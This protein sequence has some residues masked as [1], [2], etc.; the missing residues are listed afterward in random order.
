[1]RL[2][3]WSAATALAYFWTCCLS[4][5]AFAQ[6]TARF[7]RGQT[8]VEKNCA[9]CHSVTPTGSSRHGSAPPFRTLGTKYPI[10]HLA[11]ALAEGIMVGHSNMPVFSLAPEEIAN[12]LGYISS[13]QTP[14]GRR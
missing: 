12:V 7:E 5:S 2:R 13:L 8:F 9:E 4:D 6:S 3:H 1:M 14:P 11:E 10:E